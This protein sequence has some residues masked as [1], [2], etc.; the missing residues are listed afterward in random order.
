MKLILAMSFI[1]L[2]GCAKNADKTQEQTRKIEESIQNNGMTTTIVNKFI[3]NSGVNTIYVIEYKLAD[4]THCIT[5]TS[6]NNIS[7][8]C[9]WK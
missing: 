5:T 7:T 4:S 1:M 3:M 8:T 2:V 9:N 6:S